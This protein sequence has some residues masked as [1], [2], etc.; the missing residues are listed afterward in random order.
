MAMYSYY[1]FYTV[2]R[3]RFGSYRDGTMLCKFGEGEQQAVAR[4]QACFRDVLMSGC[5][6][7]AVPRSRSSLG[8]F[9][10]GGGAGA[11]PRA[12]AG[13]RSR[14]RSGGSAPSPPGRAAASSRRAR[15]RPRPPMAEPAAE[16]PDERLLLLAEPPP[17]QPPQAKLPLR[18]PQSVRGFPGGAVRQ[19]GEPGLE[20]VEDSED[21][22]ESGPEGDGED[23]PLLR[24]SGSGRGRRAGGGWDKERRAAAG[25]ARGA[26]GGAGLGQGQGQ[27]CLALSCQRA[28]KTP[29]GTAVPSLCRVR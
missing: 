8:P 11:G 12:C 10:A 23:E 19:C 16:E 14:S 18:G 17:S 7:F 4:R 25:T 5:R 13:R 26:A 24:A 28:A 1:F 21:S 22:E 3:L 6:A 20:E 29:L 27:P 2:F 15:P 9:K